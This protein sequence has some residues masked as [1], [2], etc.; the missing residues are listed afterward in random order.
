MEILP[1]G[2]LAQQVWSVHMFA[3]TGLPS[4]TEVMG[5]GADGTS[6]MGGD[7]RI[8]RAVL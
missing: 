4:E 2:D 6:C 8:Q 1:T 5:T 7:S 3:Q